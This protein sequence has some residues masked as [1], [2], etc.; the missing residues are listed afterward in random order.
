V[1]FRIFGKELQDYIFKIKKYLQ[2]SFPKYTKN[3]LLVVKLCT[4]MLEENF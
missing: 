2:F 3:F 1:I 4:E